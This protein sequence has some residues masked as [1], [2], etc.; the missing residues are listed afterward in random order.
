MKKPF[1]AFALILLLFFTPMMQ[2][3]AA[4]LGPAASYDELLSLAAS[5]SEGD[6]LLIRGELD[7]GSQPLSADVYVHLVGEEGAAI[8]GLALSNASL[9]ISGLTLTDGLNV[10]G[11]SHV[12]LMRGVCIEDGLAFTGSGALLLDPG[13]S[14]T[15]GEGAPGVTISHTGGDLYTSLDG[16]IRGGSGATGGP[17]VVVDPLGASGAL[18]IT[19]TL[20]GGEGEAFGGN[21]LNLHNLSGNAYITVDGRLTG[22]AGEVGGSGLQLITA[23][24]SV[25][26]SLGGQITGG[27]GNGYGGDAMLL[28]NVGGSAS[29]AL[30]GAL[31]GGD[32]SGTGS[33]PGQSLTLLGQTTAMRTSV[34][35]DCILQDGRQVLYSLAVTPLPAITSSVEEAE[36][37]VPTPT[38]PPAATIEPTP[39]AESTPTA[40]PT[41][42]PT[43]EAT[44][45]PTE[46]PAATSG[47]AQQAA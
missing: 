45:E 16:A 42:E 15:G 35:G 5:A 30:S 6:T 11:Q 47:E 44:A 1:G 22:G 10:R 37:I 31:T 41:P 34:G 23:D 39:T 36:T 4:Q 33:S 29:V 24:G 19:G 21:A 8:S 28:M 2:A 26:A 14:V 20:T 13:T 32:S 38:P 12:Q 46:I 18:M 25:T 9:S 27:R 40:E 17:A 3:F 7:A 43:A